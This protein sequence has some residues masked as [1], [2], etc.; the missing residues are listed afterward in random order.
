MR[1]TLRVDDLVERVLDTTLVALKSNDEL[2]C[3]GVFR[4]D[5]EVDAIQEAIRLYLARIDRTNLDEAGRA[6]QRGPRLR[7]Q[8]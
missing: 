3:Q 2:L 5:D 7:H 6:G 4:L 1:E 8:R